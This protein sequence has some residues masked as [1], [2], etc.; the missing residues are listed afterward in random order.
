[1]SKEL[2][3]KIA[4]LEAT[5][6]LSADTITDLTSKIDGESAR[7]ATA[8][9]KVLTDFKASEKSRLDSI[10][11]VIEKYDVGG[12]VVAKA[13]AMKAFTDSEV[14][15]EDILEAALDVIAARPTTQ[16]AETG[17]G[18]TEGKTITHTAYLAMSHAERR[19][20]KADGGKVEDA[21]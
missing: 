18:D 16:R 11:A 2:E 15:R 6:K 5:A 1:M 20:H 12:D 19:Q 4:T 9:E 10:Q 17:D 8:E 13:T 14:S 3:Q 7:V 21:K